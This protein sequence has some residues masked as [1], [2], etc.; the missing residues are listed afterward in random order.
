MAIPRR[1]HRKWVADVLTRVRTD[2][3]RTCGSG[4]AIDASLNH[5]DHVR[6]EIL[7]MLFHPDVPDF[8][9]ADQVAVHGVV[10]VVTVEDTYWLVPSDLVRCRS[11]C[12]S[13]FTSAP[14]M[15]GY[16]AAGKVPFVTVTFVAF[17]LPG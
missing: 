17:A 5:T 9:D 8:V 14:A 6:H 10:V 3:Y 11:G 13:P 4:L 12:P 2:G 16:V 1:S 15:S 7:K